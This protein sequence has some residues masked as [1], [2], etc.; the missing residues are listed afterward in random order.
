ML[1]RAW[2][3][4]SLALKHQE[5][6]KLHHNRVASPCAAVVAA[7]MHVKGRAEVR[8][9]AVTPKS[10]H[11]IHCAGRMVQA[12]LV[13]ITIVRQE[14]NPELTALPEVCLR[15]ML[16]KVLHRICQAMHNTWKAFHIWQR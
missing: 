1:T 12:S 13:S 11:T 10:H 9:A 6:G 2:S 5:T 16:V 4:M 3:A 7:A 14:N 15:T 8:T